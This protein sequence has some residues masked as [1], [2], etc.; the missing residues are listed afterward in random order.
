MKASY[1]DQRQYLAFRNIDNLKKLLDLAILVH[2]VYEVSLGKNKLLVPV[3]LISLFSVFWRSLES[4]SCLH[5]SGLD[6]LV[7]FAI[8]LKHI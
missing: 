8:S 1:V 6:K 4:Q 3:S 2:F 7:E 5:I